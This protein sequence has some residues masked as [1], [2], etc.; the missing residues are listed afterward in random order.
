M[1][2]SRK[3]PFELWKEE[4]GSTVFSQCLS[5]AYLH[6]VLMQEHLSKVFNVLPVDEC[7][8]QATFDDLAHS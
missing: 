6:Y 5:L 4:I 7:N 1:E 8:E 3:D 2:N